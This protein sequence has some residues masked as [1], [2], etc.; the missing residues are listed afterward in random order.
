MFVGTE[1]QIMISAQKKKGRWLPN[2]Q[3]VLL[4]LIPKTD[5]NVKSRSCLIE[6]PLARWHQQR[7]R[8]AAAK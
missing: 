4:L 1:D 6:T 7:A 5:D 8:K 2:A 3:L